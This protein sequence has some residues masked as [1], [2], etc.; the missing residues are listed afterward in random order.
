MTSEEA[1]SRQRPSDV[2]QMV[3]SACALLQGALWFI[4][5]GVFTANHA[6]RFLLQL[7]PS[8][9]FWAVLLIVYAI[10]GVIGL[11]GTLKQRVSVWVSGALLWTFLGLEAIA[12]MATVGRY[13]ILGGF[14]ALNGIGLA[15]RVILWARQQE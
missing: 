10:L 13:S 8:Q 11:K 12:G 1:W 14:E 7:A 6:H 9:S 4:H 15:L 3:L 5:P 2:W